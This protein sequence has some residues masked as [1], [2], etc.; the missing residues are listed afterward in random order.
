MAK[1]NTGGIDIAS[2]FE[3]NEARHIDNRMAVELKSEL[4]NEDTIPST[5]LPEGLRIWVQETKR[6]YEWNGED[7]TDPA[8]WY[9]GPKGPMYYPWNIYSPYEG[10]VN[11][12]GEV[13]IVEPSSGLAVWQGVSNQL[14]SWALAT[15]EEREDVSKYDWFRVM[16][17][18]GINGD[19]FRHIG[20]FS[21]HPDE[22]T[23]QPGDSYY[24]TDT[25]KTYTWTGQNWYVMAASIK[26]DTG[27]EGGRGPQGG[28]GPI[29]PQGDPGFS[30]VFAANT[31]DTLADIQINLPNPNFNTVAETVEGKIYI[32]D[33]KLGSPQWRL[34]LRDGTDGKDGK[35][36]IILYSANDP[37]I[38]PDQPLGSDYI[39]DGEYSDIPEDSLSDSAKSWYSDPDH[40]TVWLIQKRGTLEDPS[41]AFTKPLKFVGQNGAKGDGGETGGT[42]PQGPQ[43]PQGI[44]GLDGQSAYE[45]W[46]DS[47]EDKTQT[48]TD[49]IEHLIGAEGPRGVEGVKGE[50]GITK[51]TW[52]KYSDDKNGSDLSNDSEGKDYICIAYNKDEP[53]AIDPEEDHDSNVGIN[54]VCSLLKGLDGQGAYEYWLEENPDKSKADF[55]Q[56]MKGDTGA[57]GSDGL[58]GIKGEPGEKG[59]TTYIWTKYADNAWGGNMTD[60]SEDAEYIGVAYN[61]PDLES[62]DPDHDSNKPEVYAWTKIKGKDGINGQSA[63]EDW[64]FE[65]P[66][67][68]KAE[69]LEALKGNTGPAGANGISVKGDTGETMY[70][71]NKYAD[72]AVGTNMDNSSEGKA[73]VGFAYNRATVESEDEEESLDATNYQ[74]S[75]IQGEDGLSINY[76][77]LMKDPP[78]IDTVAKN[79]TYKDSDDNVIY[80]KKDHDSIGWQVMTRDGSDGENGAKGA[81][82][83]NVYIIY[84]KNPHDLKPEKPVPTN[85]G[86]PLQDGWSADP[87]DDDLWFCQKTTKLAADDPTTAWGPVLKLVGKD[88]SQ[89][90]RVSKSFE[91]TSE[92]YLLHLELDPIP[93]MHKRASI[94]LRHVGL[95]YA[96]LW[97][98]GHLINDRVVG[99]PDSESWHSEEVDI[100]LLNTAEINVITVGYRSKRLLDLIEAT[101]NDGY[102]IDR[103]IASTEGDRR[104]GLKGTF[105]ELSLLTETVANPGIKGDK[106]DKGLD[107]DKGVSGKTVATGYVYKQSE[108]TPPTDTGSK[109]P[110]TAYSVMENGLI[111]NLAWNWGNEPPAME[112]S[113]QGSSSNWYTCRWVWE[114]DPETGANNL[115]MSEPIMTTNFSGI[116]TFTALDSVETKADQAN[117]KAGNAKDKAE[118]A[119]L[120]AV[121]AKNKAI[122]AQTKADQAEAYAAAIDAAGANQSD[123]DKLAN[124][125]ETS[126]IDGA[127]ITTGIIKS[128]NYLPYTDTTIPF[129]AAGT[130]INL[131]DGYIRSKNFSIDSAG[132]TV[133][134]TGIIGNWDIAVQDGSIRDRNNRIILDP[135]EVDPSIRIKDSDNSD[136]VIL[137]SKDDLSNPQGL[138][139]ASYSIYSDTSRSE[140]VGSVASR[141]WNTQGATPTKEYVDLFLSNNSL[142]L[143]KGSADI[144]EIQKPNVTLPDL[145]STAGNV[146]SLWNDFSLPPGDTLVEGYID[147][148][149]ATIRVDIYA[150][151]VDENGDSLSPR[152]YKFLENIQSTAAYTRY[153]SGY[154]NGFPFAGDSSVTGT[155]NRALENN[156]KS[157]RAYGDYY[158]EVT[159]SVPSTGNYKIKVYAEI[160]NI[161]QT[162]DIV[163]F[164]Y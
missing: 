164:Y 96:Y 157:G 94:Q 152:I 74:W 60:L 133:F 69:F 105:K 88:A 117:T 11:P 4:Y 121:E 80:I 51:W 90:N 61:K 136:K 115:V 53:E 38:I 151:L 137:N 1:T 40:H 68:T 31:Y 14:I 159:F 64:L 27:D 139:E 46:L 135:N 108:G 19:S 102:T 155:N 132:N 131:A 83:T 20:E 104:G 92:E 148:N 62:S 140:S 147:T 7:R 30:V 78:D 123:L 134:R 42:G 13:E 128:A 54:Y 22:S 77:G 154:A 29:G 161:P 45:E 89:G 15:T 9:E 116:V 111:T 63:Y 124:D 48:P 25:K 120:K 101:N 3:L 162:F 160:T 57:A 99:A 44:K 138:E 37:D 149:P 18:P 35:G 16:G 10:G 93:T 107:G 59:E 76:I 110:A 85:D 130:Q 87:T 97:V 118:I 153:T 126:V 145:P 2:G 73:Y 8:N 43:G 113:A 103:T 141:S 6:S 65:N 84:N 119:R 114:E 5:A 150:E 12:E 100:S 91:F 81:D 86:S 122:D 58:Q 56:D 50:D 106:G 34:M 109:Y 146:P 71:W 82:G 95:N 125:M 41:T 55:L 158:D 36:I 32:F 47:Q 79:T 163:A 21:E 142:S 33:D 144:T 26:G 52:I 17:N 127:R 129:S 23:L 49:F 70:I 24:N 75:K 112:P 66:G 156:S 39:T 98:N 143:Q 67:K 28:Q 72:D